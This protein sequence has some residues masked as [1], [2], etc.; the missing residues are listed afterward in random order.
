M[1]TCYYAH[2]M[3]IYNTPAEVRDMATLEAMGFQVT[4]PNSDTVKNELNAYKVFHDNY[5]TYFT[6]LVQEH[7]IVAFRALP[8]GRLPAGVAMEVNAGKDAG[9]IIIEL[10]CGI[11]SRTMD[12]AE[13]VEYLENIGQR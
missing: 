2:F 1:K 6:D 12:H 3:G 5:M 13:T 9:K 10:P 7:D 8:D 4:N 11:V